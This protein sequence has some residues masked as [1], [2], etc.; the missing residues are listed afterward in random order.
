MIHYTCDYCRKTMLPEDAIEIKQGK[1][2]CKGCVTVRIQDMAKA[3]YQCNTA[4][5][6][7]LDK[8]TLMAMHFSLSEF[9]VRM[10]QSPKEILENGWMK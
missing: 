5:I 6:R 4:F 8:D 1:H 7:M 3:L 10:N 9:F 2:I